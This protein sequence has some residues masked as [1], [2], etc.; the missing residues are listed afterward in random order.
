M[1]V[2]RALEQPLPLPQPR[3]GAGRLPKQREH[4]LFALLCHCGA[5]QLAELLAGRPAPLGRLEFFREA[6]SGDS[7]RQSRE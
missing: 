7:L 4:F 1:F 6:H 5:R 3:I 2:E